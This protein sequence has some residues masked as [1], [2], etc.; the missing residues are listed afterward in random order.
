MPADIEKRPQRRAFTAHYQ[1]ALAGDA[2]RLVVA[3]VRPVFLAAD[4]SPLAEEYVLAF[5]CEPLGLDV[6]VAM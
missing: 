2:D 4:T 3:L 6:Q 1:Q 5:L